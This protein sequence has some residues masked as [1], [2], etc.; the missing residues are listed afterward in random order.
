[1]Q[2]VGEMF[3]I[4]Q[5]YKLCRFLLKRLEM[6]WFQMAF[7]SSTFKPEMSFSHSHSQYSV[8]HGDEFDDHIVCVSYK[9]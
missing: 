4:M 1:M 5:H 7:S 9:S 3:C 6:I 8:Q 2:N